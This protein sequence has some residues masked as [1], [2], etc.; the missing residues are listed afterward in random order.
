VFSHSQNSYIYV[1]LL[2]KDNCRKR[3]NTALFAISKKSAPR[4]GEEPISGL[5]LMGTRPQESL[6][7]VSLV[8]VC[9]L[10]TGSQVGADVN[11]LALLVLDLC[12]FENEG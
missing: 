6:V 7:V 3:G 2:V 4:V 12:V 9:S 8:A 10:D 5:K 1:V 11:G